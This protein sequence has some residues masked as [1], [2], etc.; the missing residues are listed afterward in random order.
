MKARDADMTPTS[1]LSNVHYIQEQIDIMTQLL[2]QMTDHYAIA[3]IRIQ[4]WNLE[5]EQHEI[6]SRA[7]H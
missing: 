5:A 4:L 1:N 3:R 7:S 2:E 6:L